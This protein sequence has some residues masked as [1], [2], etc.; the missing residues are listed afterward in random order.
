MCL[1]YSEL[2]VYLIFMSY[3]NNC[4]NYEKIYNR[5]KQ[6]GNDEVNNI[7]CYINFD[8]FY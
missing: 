8:G 1:M 7:Y 2:F 4:K 5:D 6:W 3:I